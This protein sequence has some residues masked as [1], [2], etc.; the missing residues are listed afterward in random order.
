ML[1]NVP[2]NATIH[3]EE[4]FGPAVNLYPVDDL[5]Q[6]IAEAN[7]V[8]YGLHAAGF[9][10][11]VE[12]C[13][14]MIQGLDAG[15]VLINDSTDYRLDSMPF[16]GVKSSGLGP[17]GHSL[18]ARRDD[19]TQGRVL[20]SARR[21]DR[22]RI[23]N[24]EF[25][26]SNFSSHELQ[27]GSCAHTGPACGNGSRSPDV[28]SQTMLGTRLPVA[29][30]R[31]GPNHCL[32]GHSRAMSSRR[33]GM[34]ESGNARGNG[35]RDACLMGLRHSGS[36]RTSKPSMLVTAKPKATPDGA[37]VPAAVPMSGT[38]NSKFKIQNCGRPK[39]AALTCGPTRATL[40]PRGT[41]WQ[42]TIR[43]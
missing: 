34:I 25:R 17:R 1:E 3:H 18:L 31:L 40:H 43:R 10:S 9:S 24:F 15:S 14:R 30:S 16:G 29:S 8:D 19:R 39:P 11:D 2:K 28:P 5:D 38:Q 6:A 26:I 32:R 27:I 35:T 22:N 21:V 36:A 41:E 4:V 23:S 37:A 12:T 20:V 42:L 7:S 33:I 13:H